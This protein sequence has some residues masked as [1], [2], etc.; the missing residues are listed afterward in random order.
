M[1]SDDETFATDAV[2]T[3]DVKMEKSLKNIN[4]RGDGDNKN[5]NNAN[6]K[7]IDK[8][9]RTSD[10]N[11]IHNSDLQKDLPTSH[12]NST[13]QKHKT[14]SKHKRNKKDASDRYI[15]ADMNTG[16][17]KFCRALGI[18]CNDMQKFIES[19]PND[20]DL[21]EEIMSIFDTNNSY[22]MA[23]A[24]KRERYTKLCALSLFKRIQFMKERCA[25]YQNKVN[26]C[27]NNIEMY[28]APTNA[29]RCTINHTS[30]CRTTKTMKTKYQKGYRDLATECNDLLNEIDANN[31]VVN[32]HVN[33]DDTEDIDTDTNHSDTIDSDTNYSDTDE[34]SCTKTT[35]IANDK[36]NC[37][38]NNIMSF[39]NK[40]KE[41]I[42]YKL[43]YYSRPDII[44]IERENL[45]DA[46]NI[47]KNELDNIS[48][49][50][51]PYI[52]DSTWK[53][54]ITRELNFK[55]PDSKII[56]SNTITDEGVNN[57]S[58]LM[59]LDVIVR[60]LKRISN[61]KSIKYHII[62]D[63]K[64]DIHWLLIAV[65]VNK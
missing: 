22:D 32:N 52:E 56:F 5:K 48:I 31:I 1:S 2:N 29:V 38:V 44:S 27:N 60:Y 15:V 16:M 23:D 26:K 8:K 39:H 28:V 57:G 65:S 62:E 12:I 41:L 21:N 55:I 61:A 9:Y 4:I 20:S 18:N 45:D 3:R 34:G 30:R 40:R 53:I 10:G 17:P 25:V 50:L 46:L 37:L 43:M 36:L 51:E 13:K 63:N 47:I 14:K 19:V 35:A 33:D 54:N 42:K 58:L 6:N 49:I 24:N 7:N 11:I 64:Y 59:H